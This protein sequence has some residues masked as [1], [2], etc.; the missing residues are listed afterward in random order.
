MKKYKFIVIEM[1]IVSL[2]I[3]ASI[4]LLSDETSAISFSAMTTR[5]RA[6]FTMAD[7]EQ[8]GAVGGAKIDVRPLKNGLYDAA[9]DIR[10]DKLMPTTGY[11]FEGWLVDPNA[12]YNLSLG[13]FVTNSRGRENFSFDQDMVNF[14]NYTKLM[15]TREPVNDMDTTPGTIVLEAN[16]PG[17][18]TTTTATT[19]YQM[20]ATLSGN[21]EVPSNN[22]IA[23]GTGSFILNTQNNTLTYNISFDNLEATQTAAHIHGPADPDMNAGVLFTLPNGK[24][25]NGIW[26]YSQNREDDI[27]DGKTYVNVHSTKYPDGEIRGQIIKQ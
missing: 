20:I 4:I 3:T 11:V 27:L 19:T 18:A 21:K 23:T 26:N 16:I 7:V 6:A 14:K 2:I 5:I 1:V 15:V 17:T 24:M 13:G 12:N 9:I 8:S 25:I 10:V 22:S